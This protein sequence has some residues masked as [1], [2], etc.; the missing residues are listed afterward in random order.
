[1]SYQHMVEFLR[2]IVTPADYTSH[3]LKS[4]WIVELT[5][6]AFITL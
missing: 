1:M 4:G 3:E 6:A 5:T 2:N